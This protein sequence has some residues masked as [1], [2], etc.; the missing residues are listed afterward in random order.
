MQ[1]VPSN[2]LAG[3]VCPSYVERRE[4]R[5][6][7]RNDAIRSTDLYTRN[8]VLIAAACCFEKGRCE[9]GLR[10]AGEQFR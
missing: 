7:D 1:F 6:D 2:R 8:N 3:Y 9:A 5:A 4:G 10:F